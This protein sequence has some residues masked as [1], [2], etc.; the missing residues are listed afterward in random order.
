MHEAFIKQAAQAHQE[1]LKKDSVLRKL[2]KK[3]I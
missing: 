3:G 2:L 1:I